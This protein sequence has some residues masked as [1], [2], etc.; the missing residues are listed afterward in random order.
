MECVLDDAG[1]GDGTS[2][3]PEEELAP[4]GALDPASQVGRTISV[5]GTWW[6]NMSE[7]ERMLTYEAK[8]MGYE[9]VP[10]NLS[11]KARPKREVKRVPTVCCYFIEVVGYEEEGTYPMY[12]VRPYPH[13]HKPLSLSKS[14]PA[15]PRL[16]R[17]S[18]GGEAESC[19]APKRAR[20]AVALQRTS[21]CKIPGCTSEGVG[22]T[23]L[24]EL[25]LYYHTRSRRS[26]VALDSESITG[27]N[28]NLSSICVFSHSFSHGRILGGLCSL[29]DPRLHLC[30]SVSNSPE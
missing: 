17:E 16:T 24:K 5:P 6:T 25:Q 15:L 26:L 19:D 11:A 3:V 13:T 27:R 9:L 14:I 22:Q 20:C 18:R 21:N 23:A 10:A 4:D 7:E 1:L 8:V 30:I 2:T 29:H 12:Q 28:S